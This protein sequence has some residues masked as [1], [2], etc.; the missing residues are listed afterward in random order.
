VPPA[1]TSNYSNA[2]GILNSGFGK[3]LVPA[4][5]IGAPILLHLE[6]AD[7]RLITRAPHAATGAAAVSR[8]LNLDNDESSFAA[9]AAVN[10]SLSPGSLSSEIQPDSNL[11]ARGIQSHPTGRELQYDLPEVPRHEPIIYPEVTQFPGAIYF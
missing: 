4:I 3:S 11:I 6:A 8:A 9:A 5:H 7:M 2:Q 1:P 10:Q